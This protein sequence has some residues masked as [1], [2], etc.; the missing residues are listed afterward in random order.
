MVPVEQVS[1]T[2]WLL[3]VP[4]NPSWYVILWILLNCFCWIFHTWYLTQWYVKPTWSWKQ[5]RYTDRTSPCGFMYPATVV[6]WKVLWTYGWKIYHSK[7]IWTSLSWK[8]YF[9]ILIKYAYGSMFVDLL[10]HKFEWK[11]VGTLPSYCVYYWQGCISLVPKAGSSF[12]IT[13]SIGP[14]WK[15]HIP[16][17]FLLPGWCSPELWSASLNITV[18]EQMCQAFPR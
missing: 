6:P 13:G 15:W 8:F 1:W 16:A 17:Y 4:S 11:V 7:L 14:I 2:R 9:V 3:E 10:F 18:D 12:C 5:H